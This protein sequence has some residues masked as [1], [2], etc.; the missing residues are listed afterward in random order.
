MMGIKSDIVDELHRPTRKNFKRRRVILKGLNDLYQADLVEMIPYARVNKGYRYILVVIN[1]F[2]KY[3]WA[4]PVKRKTGSDVTKA[5]QQV[6]SSKP[7]KN[8]Q[9][10]MGKEFYNKEFAALMKKFNINHYSTFSNVKSSIVERCNRTLK[11]IMWKRF[12]LQGSYKWISILQEIVTK[13]NSTIHRTTS[14]KPK[15]VTKKH[16]KQL[17]NTAYSNVKTVDPRKQKFRVGDRV[18]ISRYRAVFEKGYEPNWSHEVFK[19]VKVHLTNPRTYL[20][21]DINGEKIKGGFYD[22]ELQL[23]KHPDTYF[24]DKVLKR[25]G[26]KMF[27]KWLGLDNQHNSWISKN[28]VVL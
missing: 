18:R 11:G 20:L 6:L 28:H 25:S 4:L 7:P 21:E 22:Y 8:L 3:V 10:D 16:T 17:L 1:A 5:M 24:I 19:V 13:Y 23:T 12:S 14:L 9:T 26:N 2:S 15:D 27:V